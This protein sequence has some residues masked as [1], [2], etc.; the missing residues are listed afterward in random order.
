MASEFHLFSIG[1]VV[2]N[3][4]RF[5]PKNPEVTNM[6]NVSTVEVMGGFDGEMSFNPEV[7]TL[8]GTDASGKAYSVKATQDGS[9][10]CKWLPD[11]GN[12]LSAPDVRRGC[13]VHVYRLADTDEYYWKYTGLTNGL[14][15]LETVIIAF[16]ATPKAGGYGTNLNECYFLEVSTHEGL[17][18]LQTSRANNEPFAYTAQLNTREGNFILTDDINNKVS[19]DSREREI[20]ITN[21]DG[22]TFQAL[23]QVLT[24]TAKEAIRFNVGGTTME[25]T[26]SSIQH[27]TPLYGVTTG[28]FDIKKG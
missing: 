25:L 10:P 7:L 18:T 15:N 1:W 2:E 9:I 3:K 16:G 8:E 28:K 24:L 17:I 20:E 13:L 12:R 23:K 11:A 21:T 4:P 27:K 26:P 5:D 6:V 14:L 19:L 22:T